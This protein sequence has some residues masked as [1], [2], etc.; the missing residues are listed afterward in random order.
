MIFSLLC[1]YLTI[2]AVPSQEKSTREL[3]ASVSKSLTPL[4]HIVFSNWQRRGQ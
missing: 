3:R 1:A 4:R 2:I